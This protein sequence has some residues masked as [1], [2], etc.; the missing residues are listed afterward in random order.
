MLLKLSSVDMLGDVE[1]AVRY[2]HVRGTR[3]NIHIHVHT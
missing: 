3:I 2:D 1:T